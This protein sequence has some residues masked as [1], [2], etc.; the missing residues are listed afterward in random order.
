MPRS[1]RAAQAFLISP[2]H[3]CGMSPPPDKR[4]KREVRRVRHVSAWIK[5]QDRA[6]AECRVLDISKDGAKIV[7]ADPS[8]VPDLFQLAFF[9]GD[10]TKCC[11]VIWRQGKLLGVK[12]G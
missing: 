6:M 1:W 11:K 9:H 7:A 10:K 5:V 12:F 4:F 2:G 8:S 3:I